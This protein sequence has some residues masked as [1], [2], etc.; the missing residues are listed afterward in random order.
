MDDINIIGTSEVILK[1]VNCLKKLVK[2]KDLGKIKSLQGKH[3]DNGI[4]V[5]QE[6]YIE[7]KC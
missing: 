6:S 4:C 5:P 7:K 3:L 1:A 2:M